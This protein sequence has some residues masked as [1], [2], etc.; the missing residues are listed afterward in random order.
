MTSTSE[1]LER[2]IDTISGADLVVVATGAGMSKESGIPT[3]RDAQEGLWARYDPQQ[4]ATRQGFS[5]DPARVWGWYNYRRGLIARTEPHAGHRAVAELEALVAELIVVTQNVDGFH[6]LAGSTTVLE[7]HGNINRFKCFDHDHLIEA[8]V[9]IAESDGPVDPP[10]CPACG[11]PVRPAVVWYGEMLPVGVLERAERLARSCGVMLVVGT[12]GL[13]QP[14]AGLPLVA[15]SSGATVIEVNT[16]PSYLTPQVDVFLR[17]RAGVVL[18][19][20]VAGVARR[21]GKA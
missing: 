4:L 21:K 14:A 9:P 11:A 19:D 8:D 1:G 7:L 13:V 15:R 12:S 2:A 16:D 6:Q 5:E 17:G 3:F 18:P 10:G 20:L